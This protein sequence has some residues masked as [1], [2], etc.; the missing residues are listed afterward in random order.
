MK[1]I[2]TLYIDSYMYSV[3]TLLKDF[4][5]FKNISI[6]LF[7]ELNRIAHSEKR[8]TRLA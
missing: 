6:S 3:E 7:K 8:D 4:W 5:K 1:R 2:V